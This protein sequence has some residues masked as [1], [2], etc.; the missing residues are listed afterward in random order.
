MTYEEAKQ[1]K[2]KRL[3][4]LRIMNALGMVKF[5][6]DKYGGAKQHLRRL[7]PL[8]WLWIILLLLFEVLLYGY[9]LIRTDFKQTWKE[10]TVWW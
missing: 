6:E 2:L 10:D 7:H 9:N 1:R 8:T 5:K 3:V 4:G